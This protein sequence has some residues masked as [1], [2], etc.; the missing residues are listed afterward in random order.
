MN[1]KLS[2]LICSLVERKELLTRLLKCLEKQVTDEVEIIT[3]IDNH[4]ITTGHKRNNLIVRAIGEYV[5]FIDDDDLVSDD[6]V[7]KVLS[8][9]ELN[10]DCCSL[11][12]E[13]TMTRG[14]K[15]LKRVFKHSLMFKEW[16][17][18]E[19]VYYR[20]PNHLN[21]IKKSI[22]EQ[23]PYKNITIGEDKDFSER[24][25]PL[26]KSEA[27]IQGIIYYYFAS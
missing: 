26:I 24:V 22:V 27:L 11:Q 13:I 9:I 19:R 12:G 18:K 25:L 21:A 1:K 5:A 4:K 2:I 7:E 20:S 23:V 14:T 6:Y 10:K 16:Y 8:A 15:K 3:E 17:E